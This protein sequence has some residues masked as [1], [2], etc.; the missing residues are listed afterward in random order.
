MSTSQPNLRWGIIGTGLISSWFVQDLTLERTNAPASHTIQAVGASSLE[1]ATKFAETHLRPQKQS[2]ALYGSYEE[3][4]KDPNIDIVYI[5]IPHAFHKQSC[6]DAIAHGKHVLCEKP[7]TLNA[8]EAKEVFSA[9]SEAGVF[10]M[11]AMW[12]R[13]F[14]LVAKLR[15]LVHQDRVIGDVVRVFC[16]FSMNQNIASLGPESRLKNPA[17][18]AGSLLDIGIYSLMWGLVVL[19]PNIGDQAQKPRIA[20][21]QTLCD[22]IDTMSSMILLYPDG[23][24]GV[25]TSS[26]YVKTPA[27]FCRIE[28]TQGHILVEGVAGSAP[29]SFTVYNKN[30]Q[31]QKYEFERVGKGFYWEADAVAFDIAAG[32]TQND[33]MPWTETIRVLEMLDEVRQQ[34]GAKFP[35]D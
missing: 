10:I 6:L 19:D 25:L 2:P 11:E 5:G 35:Q 23:K 12:T 15:N 8:R 20:A 24:Q 16:D 27:E 21:T 28:G 9:A 3:L 18:G 32:R 33:V 26:T 29:R 14:P 17:L 4:Y 22:N 34:G 30:G 7:F 31:G 1:K 13:F